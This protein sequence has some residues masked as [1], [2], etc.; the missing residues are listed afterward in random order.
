M[1]RPVPPQRHRGRLADMVHL[2][3][4]YMGPYL[5]ICLHHSYC[6]YVY[7]VWFLC[8]TSAHDSEATSIALAV[9][10]VL[11]TYKGNHYSTL[12][13]NML[14]TFCLLLTNF[15]TTVLCGYRA[16][17]ARNVWGVALWFLRSVC[18]GSFAKLS[19]H[20]WHIGLL[21]LGVFSWLW[22]SQALFTAFS[23]S[24]FFRLF[25]QWY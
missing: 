3:R 18:V 16:W 8:L 1:L 4:Q 12:E 25:T 24:A 15:S 14:G 2:L 11:K 21:Q 19:K 9:F 17:W 7:F 5:S 23:G 6:R 13:Q 22:W 20:L 10:N